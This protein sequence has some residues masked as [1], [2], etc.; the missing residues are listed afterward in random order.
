[1]KKLLKAFLTLIMATVLCLQI[2]PAAL[3]EGT[4]AIEKK[5]NVDFLMW[6]RD[7]AGNPVLTDVTVD[8]IVL[9]PVY[10]SAFSKF[11]GGNW[12]VIR[13]KVEFNDP[14]EV[15]GNVGLI[16]TDGC[17]LYC[18]ASLRVEKGIVYDS[19]LEIC[20]TSPDSNPNK[21]RLRVDGQYEVAAIG[22]F[23]ES[24]EFMDYEA[25]DITIHGGYVE[26]HGGR[27]A[28]GIG[29]GR[30]A[31][32][33]KVT[34]YGGE[35]KAYGGEFYQG[36]GI[37]GGAGGDGGSV[38]VYGGSVTAESW[39]GASI[40][41]GYDGEGGD[42]TLY[43]GTFNLLSPI[44][45]AQKDKSKGTFNLGP[46][47]VM[48]D[49]SPDRKSELFNGGFDYKPWKDVITEIPAQFTI[50]PCPGPVVYETYNP[51]TDRMEGRECKSYRLVQRDTTEW[52]DGAWYVV[53]DSGT[54]TTPVTVSGTVN[55]IIKN[56][57][58]LTAN[59]GIRVEPGAHLNVYAQPETENEKPGALVVSAPENSA[60][61]GGGYGQAGGA[62]T[63]YGCDVT[64]TGGANAAGFGGGYRGKG[65]DL[66]LY[67][68]SLTANA[69]TDA[70]CAIGEGRACSS[71]SDIICG[72]ITVRNGFDLYD[73]DAKKRIVRENGKSWSE[74]LNDTRAA[75]S[76]IRAEAPVQE[77]VAYRYYDDQGNLTNTECTKYFDLDESMLYLS[78]G[79]YVL[80]DDLTFYELLVAGNAHLILTDGHTLKVQKRFPIEEGKS[81]TIYAQS[82]GTGMGALNAIKGIRCEDTSS[83]TIHG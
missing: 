39:G 70:P 48:I 3:A 53:H 65:G 76:L 11:K 49:N 60:G 1:M 32:G 63:I 31:D 81:L 13:G 20:A 21:G 52:K 19:S 80:K 7:S 55:L 10:A 72:S 64:V 83:L 28:A 8:A 67:G 68:G 44:G 9:D 47:L 56:G 61:I 43:G 62:L 38:T 4:D 73:M 18:K 36:A 69:G 51:Y 74:M 42:V 34:I 35:V 41:G 33:G 30:W 22:T 16:L 6:K 29:G 40:G 45:A 78:D 15:D 71:K 57:K 58:T 23:W 79:W 2:L 50:A 14:I 37:G 27:F 54:F 66:T 17:E 24:Y 25:G 46:G 5:E 77:A 82:N 75:V 26:A 12:Y 59:G